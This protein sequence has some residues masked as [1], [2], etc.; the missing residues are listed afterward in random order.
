MAGVMG[1][2]EAAE[3]RLLTVLLAALSPSRPAQLTELAAAA[4]DPLLAVARRHRLT[5]LVSVLSSAFSSVPGG[6][7]PAAFA[8]A[9]R[10]DRVITAARNLMLAQAAEECLRAFAAAGVPVIVLK[11]IAYER[12]LYSNDGTRPTADVDLLVPAEA[13]ARRLRRAGPSRFRAA[14][15]RAGVR[16]RRLSRGGMESQPRRGRPAPGAGAVRALPDRLRRGVGARGRADRGRHGG[17]HARSRTRRRLSRAA[18]GDRPLRRAGPLPRRFFEAARVARGVRGRRSDRARLGLL[19]AVR[20]GG[21][22]DRRLSAGLEG[23]GRRAPYRDS[24]RRSSST[25]GPSRRCRGRASWCASSRT[26]TTRSPRSATSPCRHAA[27]RTSSTNVASASARRASA[28][29]FSPRRAPPRRA[30]SRRRSARDARAPTTPPPRPA[31]LREADLAPS[32]RRRAARAA[33]SGSRRLADARGV[34]ARDQ[35]GAARGAER[36]VMVDVVSTVELDGRH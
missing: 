36:E 10:R 15:R 3:R 25:T 28:W 21:G 20:D 6:G 4:G 23:R 26:S 7:L 27:T 9:C 29:P 14:S 30:R 8:E 32:A 1:P 18:H 11:G 31:P 2:N 19:A 24:P 33:P 34:E 5:P 13:T 22:A 12:S 16:R 17:A 35:L